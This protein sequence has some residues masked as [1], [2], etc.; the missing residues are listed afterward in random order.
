[1]LISTFGDTNANST[2]RRA[3]LR[4]GAPVQEGLYEAPNMTSPYWTEDKL[5]CLPISTQQHLPIPYP[6]E[7]RIGPSTLPGAGL[8][9]FIDS[10]VYNLFA[11]TAIGGYWGP[12]TINQGLPTWLLEPESVIPDGV[13]RDG[14]THLL[15]DGNYMVDAD[16]DCAMG[17]INEGWEDANAS[18]QPNP[19]KPYEI[20]IVLK[21][22]LPAHGIYKI[23]VNYGAEY[24]Q[25]LHHRL[26]VI[27]QQF[28][29]KKRRTT[30]GWLG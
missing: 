29:E 3:E 9:L 26:G 2:L 30:Q 5:V 15:R 1:M 19:K 11:G 7:L 4:L 21:K 22:T 6:I 27:A 14:G 8:G 24:L 25:R 12:D 20:L 10:K 13:V 17:Y 16:P 28:Y 23:T 18:F